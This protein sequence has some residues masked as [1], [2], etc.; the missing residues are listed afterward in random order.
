M[1][2]GLLAQELGILPYSPERIATAV[3]EI[4]V[5]WLSDTSVQYNPVQQALIDIQRDLVKREGAHFIGLKDRESRK[6]G[7]HWGYIHHTNEDF[8]IFAPVFEEWC[9][10]HSL[11]AR[12]VAKELA[13]RKLLRVESK[14]HY[15]KRPLTGMDKCYYH[16]KREFISADLNFS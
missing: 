16:I 5:R 9:Q 4:V 12:E 3:W 14:G 10:K 11:N 1:A 8:L 13:C 6:P 15:K 7:N 2:V